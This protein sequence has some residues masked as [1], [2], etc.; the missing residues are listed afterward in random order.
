MPIRT[1]NV[2]G[3][4]RNNPEVVLCDTN[5]LVTIAWER[6]FAGTPV[7]VYCDD[8]FVRS[9]GRWLACA[10]NSFGIMN[11]G[12]DLLVANRFPEAATRIL[13]NLLN[14]PLPVGRVLLCLTDDPLIPG[15]LYAPTMERPSDVSTTENAYLAMKAILGAGFSCCIPGLCTGVGRM[16]PDEAARQ[17]RRAY[18]AD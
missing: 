5:P 17:M 6:V 12:L 8:I 7:R 4:I 3:T 18:D 11:G 14:D 1:L 9:E 10:G 2:S 15:L 13:D 16:A